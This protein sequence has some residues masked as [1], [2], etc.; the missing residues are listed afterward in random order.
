MTDTSHLSDAESPSDSSLHMRLSPGEPLDDGLRRIALEQLAIAAEGFCMPTDDAALSDKV[1]RARKAS[2]RVRALLRLVRDDIGTAVY[3]NE[4]AV[5]RDQ[6]KRLSNLRIANVLIETLDLLAAD[7]AGLEPDVVADLRLGFVARRDALIEEFRADADGRAAAR[8]AIACASA[9]IEA[10]PGF[11]DSDE[12]NSSLRL[13]P[14]VVRVYERGRRAMR[15][16]RNTKTAADFHEWRK[17][18][19]YLRYQIEALRGRLPAKL[20][21]SEQ[22]LNELSETLGA[23]HDLVDL[24]RVIEAD[25]SPIPSGADQSEL[26]AAVEQ[27][28]RGLQLA[29]LRAGKASYRERPTR[30]AAALTGHWGEG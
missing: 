25:T 14:S 13:V 17:Q 2:K 23:E 21:G 24:A 8:T 20:E 1:H 29:A 19:N 11:D 16:A 26:L 28:R 30:V 15:S 6:S 27:R 7:A 10:W 3:R 4:N 9:R 5:I 18:V 12:P 22:P